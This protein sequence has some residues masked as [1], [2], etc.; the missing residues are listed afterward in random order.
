MSNQSGLLRA[1]RFAPLFVTQ[2]L[3]ALNDNV[4]KN[5]MVVLLTFQ[6]ASWTTLK[7]ELLANLAAGVFIL[8]FFLFSATAGQL[9]DKYDKA[10]LARL[11]KLLEIG[12]VLV[13]GAGFLVHS[14]AVLF[15]ALFL[16]GLHSTLFGP[17]KYAIL[18]QHLKSEELV[19]GNALIEAGTFVA[20]L[21][22]TLLGGL[23]AGSGDGTTWITIV[24]LAIAVGGYIASRSIPIAVP[25]APTLSISANPL[26]ETWRN[27]NF[28]RENQ[29][30]FLS[31]M[32]IS[33]FWLFGALFLA[34]FPAYTKNVLGGSET[35][36]TLL[37]ATFT[38]GIG[39][40]SLLCEKLSAKRIE[41]G[42]V[43]LGS[44][45][46]TLF[47]LDLAF[48]SPATPAAGLGALALLQSASTWRVLLDLA[49]I[50]IFGGFFIVPLY[51]LVQQRSNPEHG[52]R[53]I[54]ANNI[55]NALFMVVGALAA[56]GMLAAGLTI[57]TL[58]AV[59]AICNAAVALFIYGL[60]PEFL[61]RFI[62]WMLIHTVY[63]LRVGKLDAVP[64]E[65]PAVI[66]CNHVSFVDPL[67][68]MAACPR[69]I[70]FVMDHHI[71]RWPVMNFVFRSSKAIPIAP[72][73]E[74]PAMMEKAF[75]EVGK[76]L[77]AGDL[78][79]IFPE[80]KIT[81]DGNINPFRPG[82]TRILAR[83]PVPVVPMALRGL[84]GSFFSR[85]D[86]PAMTKPFRRGVLS[87][88]ELVVGAAVPA[89]AA[90]PERLQADVTALR[91]D[92]T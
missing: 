19:G 47:A 22:G 27:I 85:K 71:F 23:L 87:R 45:G 8:P 6:A 2:F 1:R 72:A 74:D 80:G 75:D 53:I 18:P 38:F 73:K 9:A 92:W 32:G 77:D 65:G 78:V 39:V 79:G 76:A 62:V 61:L 70:R 44:I 42:L 30:V 84:W 51:A 86:G 54:A 64:E 24:G 37:L 4:L 41:L 66:I 58:F 43:P 17:V 14:L 56:A 83:N 81:A 68:I 7:P 88:V 60:V 21:L 16:L 31:I 13:A 35:A 33:W 52:A 48:A 28:A 49:L 12:I 34:Q 10:A 5:A 29:T 67:V 91:G 36:V 63:R 69:P 50:G 59:A 89:A 11:V 3:G 57:P 55:M 25:P 26:T 20:I 15:V 46:L 82:I 40:G 90:L